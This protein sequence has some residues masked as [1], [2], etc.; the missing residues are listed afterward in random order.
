MSKKTVS[1]SNKGIAESILDTSARS[2][3]AST[4]S[5]ALD[6]V[7]N[8]ASNFTQVCNIAARFLK[9]K[10]CPKAD[11]DSIAEDIAERR[12]WKA[13]T[14]EVRKS[15]V[16]VI[17]RAYVN[18]PEA[19]EAF[20]K[21]MKACSWHEGMKLARLLNTHKGN[22]KLAVADAVAFQSG[23]GASAVKPQQRVAGAL[24][25]WYAQSR[26]EKREAIK[27]AA[28]LLGLTVKWE[29]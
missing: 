12:G 29:K 4:F 2:A 25:A 11:Q 15:E 16:R 23:K 18:L 26:G 27:K 14:R 1:R 9:G 17:L 7:E 22:V 13:M 3:I 10:P 8:G 5:K 24:K 28:A 19:V 6:T 21:R 20:R